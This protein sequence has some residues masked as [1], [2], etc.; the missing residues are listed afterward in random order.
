VVHVRDAL[1]ADRGARARDLMRPVLTLPAYEPAYAALRTM[2]ER[3]SH[4]ALVRDES[5]G[6]LLGLLTLQDLLDRLLPAPASE[7]RTPEF[8]AGLTSGGRAGTEGV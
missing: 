8:A 5:G 2:R 4:L 7:P 3:R 6:R 1:A